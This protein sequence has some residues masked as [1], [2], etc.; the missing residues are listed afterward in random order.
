MQRKLQLKDKEV[1]KLVATLRSDHDMLNCFPNCVVTVNHI[2][3]KTSPFHKKNRFAYFDRK[4]IFYI[5]FEFC[6]FA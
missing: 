1:A 2:P 5:N 6:L 4:L 3:G